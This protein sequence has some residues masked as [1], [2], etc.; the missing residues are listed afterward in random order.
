MRFQIVA[1][2]WMI[3]SVCRCSTWSS[4]SMKLRPSKFH[5]L[6]PR[7][8]SAL[9]FLLSFGISFESNCIIPCD[10]IDNYNTDPCVPVA[11]GESFLCPFVHQISHCVSQILTADSLMYSWKM[12]THSL[13]LVAS[14][15]SCSWRLSYGRPVQADT[16]T[17]QL[18]CERCNTRFDKWT[19]SKKC[20]NMRIDRTHR[21][22]VSNFRVDVVIT[23][24][25]H[26]FWWSVR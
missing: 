20:K 14:H 13:R 23:H 25:F 6:Y 9:S 1:W 12:I 8:I 5:L 16:C 17:L 26:Q 7:E 24:K 21:K 11:K 15:T 19:Y 22:N 4:M 10:G 2:K 3:A 18:S